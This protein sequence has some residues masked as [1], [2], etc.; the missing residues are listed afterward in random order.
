M[1]SMAEAKPPR[2][3]GLRLVAALGVRLLVSPQEIDANALD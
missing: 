3:V 1:P 2:G